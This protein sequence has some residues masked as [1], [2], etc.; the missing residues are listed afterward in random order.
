MGVFDKRLRN[1]FRHEKLEVFE[2]WNRKRK[3]QLFTKQLSFLLSTFSSKNDEYR[4]KTNARARMVLLESNH[5]PGTQ[6]HCHTHAAFKQ[7]QREIFF[8]KWAVID[9]KIKE[10][11]KISTVCI[12]C[13][14]I[15]A[16]GHLGFD[17]SL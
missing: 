5:R 15:S 17:R 10:E 2:Q 4:L 14:Q 6:F 3:T 1:I 13:G 8:M 12:Q 16:Q 9:E 11:I 7:R